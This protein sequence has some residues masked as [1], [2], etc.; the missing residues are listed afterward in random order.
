MDFALKFRTAFGTYTTVL[1]VWWY[2]RRIELI[3]KRGKEFLSSDYL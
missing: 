2:K 1:C 3:W